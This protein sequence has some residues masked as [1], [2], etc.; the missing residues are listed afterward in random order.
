M[1]SRRISRLCSP[2]NFMTVPWSVPM[3]VRQHRV[4][5]RSAP[6]DLAHISAALAEDAPPPGQSSRNFP[7]TWYAPRSNCFGEHANRDGSDTYPF[8]CPP[9]SAGC[10]P[11]RTSGRCPS[12]TSRRARKLSFRP[13]LASGWQ[14]VAAA[15]TGVGRVGVGVLEINLGEVGRERDGDVA[16]GVF[17]DHGYAARTNAG[18]RS[19]LKVASAT[20]TCRAIGA[21]MPLRCLTIHSWTN[22]KLLGRRRPPPTLRQSADVQRVSV[23][24]AARRPAEA[25]VGLETVAAPLCALAL[26]VHPTPAHLAGAAARRAAVGR[27]AGDHRPAVAPHAVR[28]RAG[29]VHGRCVRRAGRHARPGRRRDP[30]R[31]PGRGVDPLRLGQGACHVAA[32]G[33]RR[34]GRRAGAGDGGRGAPGPRRGAVPAPGPGAAARRAGRPSWSR[35]ACTGCWRPTQQP[36]SGSACTPPASAR[37]RRSACR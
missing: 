22:R 6:R 31:W 10:C 1:R 34:R 24:A 28:P 33:V 30:P 12:C 14:Q 5:G 17:E 26:L 4:L 27:P 23:L 32:R 9:L 15:L 25:I 20:R 19:R 36:C 29:A 35:S 16:A 2:A 13:D 11:A 8:M 7:A 37:W 18:G 3:I 21:S